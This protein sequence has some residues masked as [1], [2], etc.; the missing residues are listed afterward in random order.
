MT[1]PWKKLSATAPHFALALALTPPE[2]GVELMVQKIECQ[3]SRQIENQSE[4]RSEEGDEHRSSQNQWEKH[5]PV[6]E[7]PTLFSITALPIKGPGT[8]VYFSIKTYAAE[9]SRY[10]LWK[11][12]QDFEHREIR[13]LT[14]SSTG[15]VSKIN[16]QL[17]SMIFKAHSP[18]SVTSE[19][20][21]WMIKPQGLSWEQEVTL[22]WQGAG[23]KGLTQTTANCLFSLDSVQ[24]AKASSFLGELEKAFKGF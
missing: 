4:D 24:L 2:I 15:Q 10:E 1:N 20:N 13:P 11:F 23:S 22:D 14:L 8:D 17:L 7:I 21:K 6:R 18:R 9:M 19:N 3:T 12:D 16:D 5:H